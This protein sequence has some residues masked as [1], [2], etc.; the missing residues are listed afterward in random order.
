MLRPE[1]IVS[2]SIF[3]VSQ[4]IESVLEALNSFGEFHIEQASANQ[5]PTSFN[6]AIQNQEQTLNDINNLTA[7][8]VTQKTSFT[9]MF[10][11]TEPQKTEV[12]AENW[13]ALA[14]STS[15]LVRQLKGEVEAQNNKLSNIHERIRW[16]IQTKDMLTILKEMGADLAAME[17]LKRINIFVAAVPHKYIHALQIALKGLP[18][19]FHRCY[20]AKNVDFVCLSMPSKRRSEVELILKTHHSDIFL[21][22]KDLPLNVD[23]ALK[24]TVKQLQTAEKEEKQVHK[25]L[26]ALG[27]QNSLNLASWRETTENILALVKAERKIV[28]SGRLAVIK[29]FVPKKQFKSLSQ[30]VQQALSGRVLVIENQVGRNEDPPTLIRH[31]RFVRPFEE[32]TK[33]YG[34]PEYDELDPTPIIAITFPLLFGLMFGDMGHGLLLLVGGL[35][36]GWLIKNN[37][38]MKN[39]CYILATCGVAALVAGALFGEFFGV[40]LFAPLWFSPFD[41]VLSFLIFS[42]AVGVVQ[43]ASGLILEAANFLLKG[44]RVDAVL[45]S[46]PKLAFYIGAVYLIA[47]YQLDFAAWFSGPILFAVVP[48]LVLVLAKPVWQLAA[49]FSLRMVETGGE[50]TSLGQRLFESGDLVT[51]LLSNTISYSRILALLMAHYALILATYT[52]AGLVGGTSALGL[53]LAGFV[54]VV[55]NVFV[56]ALEGLIVFIH[57]MRLHFYEWFSKF[58]Q[59]TGTEFTP[60]RQNFIYTKVTLTDKE[61]TL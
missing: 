51:R 48:F 45:T 61:K 46:L 58:Y 16:L 40:Q 53:V 37:Q 24:E 9:D 27:T 44:N 3:C 36:V 5:T 54:I 30:K 23:L 52:V 20:L 32:I 50:K 19:V 21:L 11:V 43:I 59:G 28:Q 17:K 47:A 10:K 15:G 7:Q 14:E 13:K 12:T 35:T 25:A 8:L 31:N 6:Q 55:G 33:L 56:I 38:G 41:N 57:D 60:F 26:E 18:L 2:V 42:L 1:R 29:G 49:H 34:V 22:P 4:D 39:V